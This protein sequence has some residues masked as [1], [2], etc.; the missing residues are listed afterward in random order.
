MTFLNP[1]GALI[2][3]ISVS[4]FADFWVWVTSEARGSVSVGFWGSRQLSPFGGGGSGRRAL[5]TPPP[6]RKR[7][8]GLPSHTTGPLE[9]PRPR[10]VWLRVASEPHN[11]MGPWARSAGHSATLAKLV[12]EPLPSPHPLPTLSHRLPTLFKRL[13]TLSH[14]LPT[15][16]KRLPT[17]SHRLPTLFKR[18]PTLSHRLLTLSHPRAAGGIGCGMMCPAQPEAD[19]LGGENF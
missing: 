11:T 17:L 4:F 5:S 6:H 19:T 7:K 15:L 13:P 14:R 18:L 12:A 1:L 8:P 9:F 2:P 10:L 16:F 3:K